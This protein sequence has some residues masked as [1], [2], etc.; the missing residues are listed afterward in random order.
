MQ[1]IEED[2]LA[3]KERRTGAVR[4]ACVCVCAVPMLGL[5]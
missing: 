5:N 4:T 3:R 1:Q 2:R